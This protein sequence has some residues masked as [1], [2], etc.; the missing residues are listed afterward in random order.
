MR[1]AFIY[2]AI[3]KYSNYFIQLVVQMVLSRL[4][5]PKEFG[6][7]AIM[8][9]FIIFFALMIEAGM[10][11]AIIQNK[12]LTY[13]DNNIL[14]N[15]SA[16]FAIIVS[17][18]FGF[19]GFFL[20]SF[21]SNSI[22]IQLTWLQSLSVMFDGLNIV[23]TALL[24]KSQKFK[25]VNFN[26]VT[27]NFISGTVGVILAFLG[28]GVYSLIWYAIFT[29]LIKFTLN[30]F[31]TTVSFTRKW[32]LVALKKIWVF[33]KN[34]FFFNFINYFSRNSDN[35]LIGKFLG[36]TA[37]ANYS[38][39]YQ[40]L[41]MPSSLLL[42]IIYP[43]LQPILSEYQDDVK[44]IREI[45]YKLVHFLV[46]IS[47]PLSILLS[48]TAQPIIFFLF[49]NQWGDAVFPFKSLSLTIWSQIAVASFGGIIAARNKSEILVINGLLNASITVSSIILGI[50]FGSINAVSICLTI[51]FIINF[52]ISSYTIIKYVLDDHMKNYYKLFYSPIL[53]SIIIFIFLWLVNTFNYSNIWIS[54]AINLIVFIIIFIAYLVITKEIDDVLKIFRKK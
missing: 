36:E 6:V 20:S 24:Y 16:L 17:I 26:V 4:L 34:Q 47:L 1:K 29:S 45:S 23:P 30:M 48:F 14:F 8:Q 15:F 5:T 39:S 18:I 43:V 37:I 28:F 41:T 19:F 7:V 40:L 13:Q 21:Y 51:A 53:L 27:A 33:S 9:V 44:Y 52:F 42:G 3:G 31:F 54:F 11:P 12:T 22:F 10:G 38:K 35:I 50:S 25:I 2:T 49:G 46:L 32:N